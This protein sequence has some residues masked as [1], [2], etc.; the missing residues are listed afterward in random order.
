[1]QRYPDSVA[2]KY[3]GRLLKAIEAS[4]CKVRN[5]VCEV[6]KEASGDI[7]DHTNGQ[8]L[9]D[10]GVNG[11]GA[12]EPGANTKQP[13]GGARELTLIDA[14]SFQGRGVPAREWNVEGLIP[15]RTVTLLSGDGGV[16][17]SLLALQLCVS[18]AL[19]SS[20]CGL[21]V[22]Q[23][24][25]LFLTAEDEIPELHRRLDDI[26]CGRY[27]G[28]AGKLWLTSLCEEDAV[29]A[30]PRVPTGPMEPTR[31][32]EALRRALIATKPKLLVLDSAADVFGGDEIKRNHVRGFIAMLRKLA[33]EFDCAVVLLSHPSQSGIATGGG[34]SG[35]TAWNNSV[36]SRLYFVRD[37]DRDG[38][39][40]DKDIRRTQF[41]K[42]KLRVGRCVNHTSICVGGIRRG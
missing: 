9:Y 12:V 16:G 2:I 28:L 7:I 22:A 20:W 25:A 14:G 11:N 18:T 27:T 26:I 8:V 42:I 30:V 3:K 23:G 32:Y 39:E 31:L 41:E 4:W 10:A 36:R 21:S 29:L 1:M 13:K 6:R 15:A 17:K 19:S 34:S 35:S 33:I 40:G 37:I 38:H 5:E 24:S